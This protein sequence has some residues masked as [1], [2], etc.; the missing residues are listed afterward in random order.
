MNNTCHDTLIPSA[1]NPYDIVVMGGSAGGFNA[2]KTVLSAL[3]PDFF[4]P[5][6]LVQH[7]HPSDEGLFAQH[8][9][10]MLGIKVREPWDKEPI[11]PGKVYVAPADYHMLVER[12]GTIA[13]STDEKVNWSRPSIDVLF[14]SAAFLYGNRVIGI[15]LTGASTDGT[16]GI[17]AIKA[18]GGLTIAEDPSTA[19]FPF[20]PQSAIE[21][22]AVDLVLTAEQIGKTLSVFGQQSNCFI[23]EGLVPIDESGK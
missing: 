16:A 23:C 15:I 12:G 11:E 17:R 13:L 7:L 2:F 19:E 18:A 6:L 22:G 10:M 20:M 4:M 14:E 3:T 8:M 1:P 21:S 5:V 9:A